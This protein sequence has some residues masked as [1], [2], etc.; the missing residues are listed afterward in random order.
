VQVFLDR[1]KYIF[2][3]EAIWPDIFRDRSEIQEPSELQSIFGEEATI[4]P[5][6]PHFYQHSMEHLTEPE[7]R[8]PNPAIDLNNR[9]P[10]YNTFLLTMRA[11][12]D[13]LI[14]ILIVQGLGFRLKSFRLRIGDAPDQVISELMDLQ[15]TC[16]SHSPYF[17]LWK[18]FAAASSRDFP[19]VTLLLSNSKFGKYLPIGNILDFNTRSICTIYCLSAGTMAEKPKKPNIDCATLEKQHIT[20]HNIGEEIKLP[21]YVDAVREGLVE[22]SIPLD[23]ASTKEF[24]KKNSYN[25]NSFEE[26][27]DSALIKRSLSEGEENTM[28]RYLKQASYLTRKAQKLV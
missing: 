26:I 10:R 21:A 25:D 28:T 6:D 22:F 19:H 12:P 5:T 14:H 11:P 3:Y 27:P 13:L 23:R 1:S 15:S 9:S 20:Y 17:R 2:G 16:N 18:V 24:L 7:A 8:H 4:L